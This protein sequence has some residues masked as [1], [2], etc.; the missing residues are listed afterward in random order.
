M[1]KS[2]PKKITIVTGHYGSGKSN[3]SVNLALEL[4]EK[5]EKVTVVDL[6]IVNPY[7]RTADFGALFEK[8]NI[9]L[10]NSIYA[11]TNLDIPAISFDVIRIA[12]DP[13]YVIIDVGGDDDGATAL[14]RYSQALESFKNDIDFIYVVNC[15]R[16]LTKEPE[17]ALELL[18]NIE[19]ASHMKVTSIVNNSNL[20]NMTDKDV[21][22]SSLKYAEKISQVSGLPLEFSTAPL[23]EK[24]DELD[25][26]NIKYIDRYVKPIWE[27]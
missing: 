25:K 22:L 8:H 15:Y 1:K 17:E 5:G 26:E 3:L 23:S 24:C 11:N 19:N 18:Y 27:E 13:G 14:G 7:F 12:T 16:Y 9:T 6:D 10:V 21:V 4:S 2:M 20:G